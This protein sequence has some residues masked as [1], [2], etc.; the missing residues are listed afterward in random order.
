MPL[1]NFGDRGYLAGPENAA[2][3]AAQ[4]AVARPVGQ[5]NNVARLEAGGHGHA[6]GRARIKRPITKPLPPKLSLWVEFR[7]E[8]LGQV[9]DP[10]GAGHHSDEAIGLRGLRVFSCQSGFLTLKATH[11]RACYAQQP[12]S[13]QEA[14]FTTSPPT[15]N[16]ALVGA[17]RIAHSTFSSARTIQAAPERRI[18]RRAD[19]TCGQP[20]WVGSAQSASDR[21]G[22]R[23]EFRRAYDRCATQGGA[24]RGARSIGGSLIKQDRMI[25]RPGGDVLSA[26]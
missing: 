15:K 7:A 12:D 17:L 8:A 24:P 6:P 25:R 11:S 16:L 14:R 4:Q 22:G 5:N 10:K 13:R 23:T 21:E 18:R 9:P 20:G 19:A 2:E 1:P 26:P 3:L